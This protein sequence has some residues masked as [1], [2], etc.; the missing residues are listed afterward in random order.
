MPWRLDAGNDLVLNM[1][2]KPTG[3]PEQVRAKIG[4]Y[5]AA[6]AAEARPMLIQLEHDGAL[7]IP[8]GDANF[9]VTDEMKLP[10]AVDLLGVY[11]HAH[12]WA[13]RWRRGLCCRMG[14]GSRFC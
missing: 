1:H 12:Y 4:L 7:D 13:A 10:V 14:A 3:K 2:L 6:K 9:V 11:P 8:A 5:F